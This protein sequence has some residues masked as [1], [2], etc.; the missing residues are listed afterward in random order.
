MW[1]QEASDVKELLENVPSIQLYSQCPGF[2]AVHH[3]LHSL[4]PATAFWAGGGV[5]FLWKKGQ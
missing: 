2:I 5:G 3:P 4:H 1:N